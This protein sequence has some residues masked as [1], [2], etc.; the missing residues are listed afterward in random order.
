[1]K[2]QLLLQQRLELVLKI[3]NFKLVQDL[4]ALD[5]H[6]FD[7]MMQ[8]LLK[9]AVVLGLNL[10]EVKKLYQSIHQKSL[11]VEGEILKDSTGAQMSDEKSLETLR[12]EVDRVDDEILLALVSTNN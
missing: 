10:D 4:P 7:Q 8:R 1:M 5:Q 2:L 9:K 12:R 6:R 3:A 11:E